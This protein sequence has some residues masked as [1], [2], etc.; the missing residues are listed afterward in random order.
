MKSIGGEAAAWLGEGD[1]WL[2]WG[3]RVRLLR[4]ST[5]MEATA[6]PAGRACPW[7]DDADWR[8]NGFEWYAADAVTHKLHVCATA[9]AVADRSEREARASH[10]G[11]R[12]GFAKLLR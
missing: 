3:R 11:F 6:K 2:R 1:G 5:G 12:R 9:E 4:E 7:C 8:W 10:G